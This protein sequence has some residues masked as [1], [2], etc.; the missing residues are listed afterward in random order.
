MRNPPGSEERGGF[1]FAAV[2]ARAPRLRARPRSR[3]H[4]P[5][6]PHDFS[7]RSPSTVT[8]RAARCVPVLPAGAWDIP[9]GHRVEK[10]TARDASGGAPGFLLAV[11]RTHGIGARHK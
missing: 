10:H 6:P 7:S 9:A 5:L 8:V 4:A 1:I 11:S 2:F 3:R